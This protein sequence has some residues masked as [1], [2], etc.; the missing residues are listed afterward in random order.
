MLNELVALREAAST[1]KPVRPVTQPGWVDA[2]RGQ[3]LLAVAHAANLIQHEWRRKKLFEEL[4]SGTDQKRMRLRLHAAEANLVSSRPIGSCSSLVAPTSIRVLDGSGTSPGALKNARVHVRGE[5]SS[6]VPPDSPPA[7]TLPTCDE[8]WGRQASLQSIGS[9]SGQEQSRGRG[10]QARF[11]QPFSHRIS[12]QLFQ[13]SSV[14]QSAR[15]S[16]DRRKRAE[17]ALLP[18]PERKLARQA[19]RAALLTQTDGSLIPLYTDTRT[20]DRFG[21]DVSQYFHFMCATHTRPPTR[22]PTLVL[23]T[24]ARPICVGGR[25]A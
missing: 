16:S 4:Q 24:L 14:R 7:G 15:E 2:R 13:R 5:F 22:P 23:P 19:G 21:T 12:Q 3:Q 10:S 9:T 18:K 20:F 1:N 11:S 8:E 17:A 6:M 25:H